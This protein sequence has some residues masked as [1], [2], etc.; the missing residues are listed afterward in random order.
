MPDNE[1]EL[2]RGYPL[3]WA[4][5]RPR[6]TSRKASLFRK[7]GR[8]LTLTAATMRLRREVRAI[9]RT[10]VP[11]R[12]TQMVLSSNIR[13]TLAGTRDMSVSRRDPDDP[14]VA[15]YFTLDGRPHVLACD[16]WDDVPGNIAAIAAH[17]DA[18]RGQERWGVADLRQ[19][20]AGHVAL[21]PPRTCWQILGVPAG[22][23][24][25]LVNQAFRKLAELAHPDKGGSHAVMAE[26]NQARTEALAAAR[27]RAGG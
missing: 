15:F 17:I 23:D 7:E 4:Q 2:E 20:F 3:A 21:P 26:I 6:T 13:F 22:A 14:G 8:P 10:G 19:A 11:W 5:G 1:P 27:N 12:V 9:T 18:L 16:R 24:Q 25:T